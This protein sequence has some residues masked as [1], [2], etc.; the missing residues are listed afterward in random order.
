MLHTNMEWRAL[1]KG[2]FL[3]RGFLRWSLEASTAR[4]SVLS[5]EYDELSEKRPGRTGH[6]HKEMGHLCLSS[7]YKRAS[8]ALALSRAET[9]HSS[10][11]SLSCSLPGPAPSQLWVHVP[12]NTSTVQLSLTW[13]QR[14][15]MWKSKITL[16]YLSRHNETRGKNRSENTKSKWQYWI[17]IRRLEAA[18]ITTEWSIQA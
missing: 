12:K 16:R 10:L 6:F 9:R 5:L 2:I 3:F 17:Y 8:S 15:K 18:Y 1:K 14:S 13:K 7:V 11:C 4:F